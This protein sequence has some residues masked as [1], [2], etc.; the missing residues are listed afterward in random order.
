MRLTLV[1]LDLATSY[2]L[3]ALALSPQPCRN[4]FPAATELDAGGA[5]ER[6]PGGAG[7]GPGAQGR[8]RARS[9]PVVGGGDSVLD[10][11]RL[12]ALLQRE[13]HDTDPPDPAGRVQVPLALLGRGVVW[14]QGPGREPARGEPVPPVHEPP[15]PRAPLGQ[16]RRRRLV[17]EAAQVVCAGWG[18]PVLHTPKHTKHYLQ[19]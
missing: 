15:V 10:A 9:G 2:C 7:P 4:L 11:V 16:E 12:S 3:R 8:L 13:Q 5:Q 17:A 6:G 14:G 19:H 1:R 18:P